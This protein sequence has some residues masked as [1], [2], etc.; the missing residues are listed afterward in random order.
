MGKVLIII[1]CVLTA[2]AVV[3]AWGIIII[4]ISNYFAEEADKTIVEM[5][6]QREEEREE[7][8]AE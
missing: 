3:S 4:G 2:V 5:Q 1:F 7:H 6:R 8:D